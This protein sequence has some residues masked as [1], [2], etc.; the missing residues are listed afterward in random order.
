[1]VI[2]YAVVPGD[3]AAVGAGYAVVLGD[4]DAVGAGYADVLGDPAA[5]GAGYMLLFQV[6]LLLLVLV[7]RR[8]LQ[9][10]VQLFREAGA[11]VH[12]MPLLVLLPLLVRI[13]NNYKLQ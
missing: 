11:A 10:V 12:A 9:L 1:M 5:V 6:I 2:S 4:P 13:T 3:P 8:R 7:M